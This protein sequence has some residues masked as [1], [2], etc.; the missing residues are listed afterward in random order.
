MIELLTAILN[1]RL[2]AAAWA[3]LDKA[4]AATRGAVNANVFL[5]NYAAAARRAGKRALRLDEDEE[6]QVRRVDA[7]LNLSV[8]GADEAVR[9]L[10][11]LS[12][13]HL[14]LEG[15]AELATQ[16]YELGDSREQQS[17]L[18]AVSLLPGAERHLRTAIDA[19]RTNILP[20]FEAIACENP[21]PARFFPELN[22]NQMA[23]KAL[24]SRVALSRIVGL[25]GRSNADLSRMCFDYLCEREAAGRTVP[26]DIWLA[27]IPHIVPGQLPRALPYLND[28]SPDARYWLSVALGAS[29][30]P[31][32]RSALQARLGQ[33]PDARVAGAM[34]A[35]LARL[36]RSGT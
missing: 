3:W 6:A 28:A 5:G 22:F 14:P 26:E 23:M 11:L 33:E 25:E 2:D 32:G 17:W 9:A 21:Y 30:L 7:G 1:K 29:G 13:A 19:C 18:R 27:L 8:W 20:L 16:C 15:H 34:Q 31:A 35:S 10:L 4:L 36:N 12:L 24:F